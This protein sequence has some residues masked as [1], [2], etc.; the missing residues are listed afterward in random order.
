M[1]KQYALKRIDTS[2]LER[3]LSIQRVLDEYSIVAIT[4]NNGTITYANKEFCR[5]SK[6]SEDELVGQNHR[7]LKSGHHTSEFYKELWSTISLGKIWRGEIK[8]R[9]KDGTFYWVK[10]IIVPLLDDMGRSVEYVSIRTDIT[11]EKE[12][13]QQYVDSVEKL[14]KAEKLSAIGELASRLAHDLRNS[15]TILKNEIE[16]SK[17]KLGQEERAKINYNRLEKALAS[18]SQQI[19]GVLDFVRTRPLEIKTNSLQK[20]I[21]KAVSKIAKSNEITIITPQTNLSIDCDAEQLEIAL[22]NLITNSIEAI[23]GAGRIEIKTKKD[24]SNI[25]I[26]VIDSGQGISPEIKSKIWEPLFT[27]KQNGTGLGL[28]SV[29]DIIVRHGGAISI[30]DNP[31][32]FRITMPQPKSD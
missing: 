25:I 4:D 23:K 12:L 6:F 29:E 19:E 18:I 24:N 5:I 28:A 8:N 31:T 30:S 32:T 9:A 11:K 14:V 10:T 2:Q 16:L 13:Q 7:I 21:N 22:I 3:V 1:E 27:T 26:E 15:V 17:L 20:I